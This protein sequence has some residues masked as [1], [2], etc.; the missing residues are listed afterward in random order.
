MSWV[1]QDEDADCIH[2]CL[3]LTLAL[4]DEVEVRSM[5]EPQAVENWAAGLIVVDQKRFRL[6]MGGLLEVQKWGAQSKGQ[7][8]VI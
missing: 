2:E 6:R 7:Q 3:K 5:A 4:Q 1:A 8:V